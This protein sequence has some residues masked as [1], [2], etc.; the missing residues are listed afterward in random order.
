MRNLFD[1]TGKTAAVIGAGSDIG[2]AV[3]IGCAQHGARVVCL[4]V[5][6]AAAARVQAG[7][8]LSADRR[9]GGPRYRRG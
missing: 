4:D 2:E 1:L 7:A 8:R 6:E 9:A 3:T 5:H